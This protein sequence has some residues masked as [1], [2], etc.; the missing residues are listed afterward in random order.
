MRK[1]IA[2]CEHRNARQGVTPYPFIERGLF[3]GCVPS[4]VQNNDNALKRLS[5]GEIV[6]ERFLP[7]LSFG[8]RDLRVSVARKVNEVKGLVYEIIIHCPR[9]T[10]NR[11]CLCEAFY[12]G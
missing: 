11:T 2:L 7:P 8:E 12:A 4:A 3:F 5:L 9:L 1:F 10:R 6:L